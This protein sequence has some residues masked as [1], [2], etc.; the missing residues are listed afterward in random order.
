MIIACCNIKGG[1]GKTTTA[2]ALATLAARDGKRVTVHDADPQGTSSAWAMAA[3]ANGDALPF[4]VLAA[5]VATIAAM[6]ADG[7]RWCFVDCPPNGAVVDEAVARA[8]IVVIPTTPKPADLDKTVQAAR[9]VRSQGKD[10]AILVTM[11][12]RGTLSERAAFELLRDEEESFF[13][14]P[15][16]LKE[17][18]S[19][20][21]CS[22]FGGDLFGYE[23]VYEE[24]KELA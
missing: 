4:A 8:D 18:V 14:H 10:Y 16:Y 17:S 12:R 6:R 2:M 19:E 13:E 9:A 22:A 1:V 5:N 3:D 24:L 20:T 7:D 21:F 23:N 11:A 15:I